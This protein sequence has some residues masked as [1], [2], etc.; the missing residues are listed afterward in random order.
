MAT[1]TMTDTPVRVTAGV[2]THRDVHLVAALDERGAELGVQAFAA[3]GAG[4]RRT[5]A[6]LN[7]LGTIERVGVEGTGTYGAGLT[8]YL[9]NHNITVIEVTCPNRQRRR[10][11][12]KSDPVDAVAAAHA[13]QSGDATAH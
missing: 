1:T 10:S 11:H 3:D 9:H 4:Y 5:L 6:W 12:G 2:D 13:A 7:S 8:R